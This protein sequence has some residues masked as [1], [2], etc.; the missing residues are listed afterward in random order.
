MFVTWKIQFSSFFCCKMISFVLKIRLKFVKFSS[1]LWKQIEILTKH[2]SYVMDF[3]W[4]KNCLS[5][6]K[7]CDVLRRLVLVTSGSCDIW[8]LWHLVLLTSGSSDVR[9][10]FRCLVLVT[11]NSFD[12]CSCDVW[13]LSTSCNVW[14]L[15][16]LVLVTS[17]SFDVCSCD[18]W[19]L[20]T[21]C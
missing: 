17:S 2:E 12:V 4:L 9:L 20:S 8:F 1:C 13:L 3:N 5:V 6:I 18:V 21:S 11:S 16:R 7:S 14:F 15:W 19:F 10:F